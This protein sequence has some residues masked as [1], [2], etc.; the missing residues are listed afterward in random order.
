MIEETQTFKQLALLMRKGEGAWG[1]IPNAS[2][3]PVSFR[4]KTSG[5]FE[6][7]Q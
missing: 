4:S 1:A 2:L 3:V 5:G 6:F 7:L